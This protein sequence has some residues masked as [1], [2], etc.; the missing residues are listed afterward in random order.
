MFLLFYLIM[1]TRR[2]TELEREAKS[3]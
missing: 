3:F 2:I 1:L